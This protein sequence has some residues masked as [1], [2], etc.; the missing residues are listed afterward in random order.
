MRVEVRQHRM[1][2]RIVTSSICKAVA[3]LI[4]NCCFSLVFASGPYSGPIIDM[5]LHA[6]PANANGPAP[7]AV[8]VGFAANLK[9]D[10]QV[11]WPA[12]LERMMKAPSCDKPIQGPATDEEVRDQTIAYMKK[13]NVRGVLSGS[14]SAIKQWQA[15][16]PDMFIPGFGLN[17]RRDDTT[18]EDIARLFD[19]G[20]LAV[21]AEV[22]NQYSGV[23][24]DDP[25]F[26][27]YWE[28]AAEKDI[29][30]GI[31]IGVGPPGAP[32][33]YPDFLVQN[34][35]RMEN[36]LKR[37][38][39]LRV[40]LMH[41]AYPF[42]D[43]LKSLLYLYPQLYV[44]TGVLQ[45]ALPREEYYRFLENLVVSGFVDRIM[46]GSDQMNW[47]GAIEE[48]IDAI[49]EAPFLTLEQ[50]KAIFHDNAKRFL[51]LD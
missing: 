9:Y 49:N 33:L 2:T 34:P 45:I 31:H 12:V 14:S 11:P 43:D 37:H 48:G 26:A 40:Y 32:H 4:L 46:F 7:N 47:P 36:V 25:D 29:P 3:V 1:A 51:R 24:A 35:L 21:L 16:A 23:F 30:V 10:P 15:V 19:D 28:V 39:T 42:V 18:P 41:A 17:I 22:T 13:Y 50:K 38:P 27:P 20:D 8:C 5:H 44:G 6:Y